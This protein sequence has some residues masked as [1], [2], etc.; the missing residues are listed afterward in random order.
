MTRYRWIVIVVVIGVGGTLVGYWLTVQ[1]AVDIPVPADMDDLS[2]ELHALID[3]KL[4]A[5]RKSPRDAQRWFDLAIVYE[6]N[7]M[8]RLGIKSYQR[9]I[10]LERENPRAWYHL[11]LLHAEVAED[12]DA[13]GAWREVIQRESDFAPAHW[14]TGLAKLN[15][16]KPDEAEDAFRTAVRLDDRDWAARLGL[17]RAW[18][19]LGKAEHAVELLE[20]L[21]Q[22]PG[23]DT[24]YINLLLS[25][26]YRDIGRSEDADVAGRLGRGSGAM[27]TD[28]WERSRDA[29]RHGVAGQSELGSRMSERGEHEQA[30]ALFTQLK[31]N[32]EHDPIVWHNLSTALLSAGE[33]ESARQTLHDALDRFPSHAAIHAALSRV[34]AI[35][36]DVV[37]PN[38][39]DDVWRRS[40]RHANAA[41]LANPNHAQAHRVRGELLLRNDE[42]Q[43]ALE[44][45]NNA[46]SQQ[47]GQP[48]IHYMIGT[49]HM[50]LENPRDALAAFERTLR[51]NPHHRK[52]A[53]NA[54][55]VAMQIAEPNLA[56]FALQ[57]ARYFAPDDPRVMELTSH[58]REQNK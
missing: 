5:I 34:Y 2:A 33:I 49:I 44:A 54:I 11:G 31:E 8:R 13:I 42:P 6:A 21:L 58:M 39:A 50:M 12:E 41:L 30:I 1:P 27:L 38:V 56:D 40:M 57:R 3:E 26:A 46:A 4:A 19:E 32:Y 18:L 22:W 17:A 7:E 23:L 14:R 47:P 48:N 28:Q 9:G 55:D 35:M 45:L 25:A 10:D 37:E 29:Y 53:L 52:A 20:N 15:M 24:A 16:G 43:R 51:L 36:L